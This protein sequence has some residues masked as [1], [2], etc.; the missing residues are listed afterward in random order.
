MITF[1]FSCLWSV[2]LQVT[3]REHKR[4][5]SELT[6]KHNEEISQLRTELRE[7]ME[8][9]HQAELEQ[10][11]VYCLFIWTCSATALLLSI[12]SFFLFFPPLTNIVYYSICAKCHCKL[13][14]LLHFISELKVK[15]C[16]ML[17]C[18]PDPKDQ[19]TWSFAS[20][21][22]QRPHIPDRALQG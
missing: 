18:P 2:L 19:W 10:A 20:K 5:V 9:A 1:S 13:M 8:A 17:L 16:V 22:H 6:A 7:S 14:W 3:E 11:Q 12:I 4:M 15:S 21:P